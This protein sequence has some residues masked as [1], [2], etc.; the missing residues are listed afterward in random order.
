[1]K[2]YRNS[3]LSTRRMKPDFSRATSG[4]PGKRTGI[5]P[6]CHPLAIA[7]REPG[8]NSAHNPGGENASSQTGL[9]PA[10][11]GRDHRTGALGDA[12]NRRSDRHRKRR[13]CRISSDDAGG[14]GSRIGTQMG[15]DEPDHLRRVGFNLTVR[16]GLCRQR[17][18]VAMTPCYRSG[19]SIGGRSR[20]HARPAPAATDRTIQTPIRIRRGNQR[21]FRWLMQ[22]LSTNDPTQ[23]AMP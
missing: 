7:L 16:S 15:R 11:V 13:A 3:S 12:G 23:E 21:G 14:T 10:G 9:A 18:L 8:G 6:T 19:R 5:C 22:I 17:R 4:F 2:R 1:M 20:A